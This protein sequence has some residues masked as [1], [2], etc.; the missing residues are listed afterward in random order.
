MRTRS[1][2]VVIQSKKAGA[3]VDA[4]TPYARS[5]TA[6]DKLTQPTNATAFRPLGSLSASIAAIVIKQ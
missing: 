2:A 5:A 4:R 1:T 6:I 3:L